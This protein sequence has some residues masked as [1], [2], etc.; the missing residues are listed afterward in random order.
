MPT[1]R[2]ETTE[3]VADRRT[4]RVAVIAIA[5]IEAMVMVPLILHL[6]GK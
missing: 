3:S 6:A 5:I 1:D 4:Q 2:P